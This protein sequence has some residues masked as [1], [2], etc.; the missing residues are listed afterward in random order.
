MRMLAALTT[1]LQRSCSALMSAAKSAGVPP[2]ALA[3]SFAKRVVIAL[4]FSA[5]LISTESLSTTLL[6]E[7]RRP[8]DSVPLRRLEAGIAELRDRR[9]VRKRRDALRRSHR[10]RSELSGLDVRHQRRRARG[11]R[12]EPAAEQ[13]LQLRPRSAVR[14]VHDVDAG[15]VLEV[16][17]REV[18]G[19][20]V[21][22]RPV[23]ELAGVLLRERD[24]FAEVLRLHVGVQHEDVGHLGE[25]RDRHEVLVHVVG[26]AL[27]RVGIDRQRADVAEDQRVAVGRGPGD[28][29]HGD[30]SGAAR[31]VVDDDA[32]AHRDGELLRHGPRDDFRGAARRERDDEADGLVR[33]RLRAGERRESEQHPGNGENLLEHGDF[34]GSVAVC[35][36]E[37]S[38]RAAA[39][40][41]LCA[42]SGG[43]ERGER[44]GRSS[45]N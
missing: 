11:S 17:E 43:S 16:F 28:L 18:A 26:L 33:I 31:A 30:G 6:R 41:A 3:S 12:L 13:V 21:A 9:H 1:L 36:R 34:P 10:D 27:H 35:G 44:G 39:R 5:L 15:H 40:R 29:E 7:L 14:D 23:V 32:D 4:V 24:E 19:A 45:Q 25:Q 38:A 20:A 37:F 22:G 2:P 42:P 8:D